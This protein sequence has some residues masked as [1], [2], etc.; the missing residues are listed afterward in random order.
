[1]IATR[2]I[3]NSVEKLKESV[4]RDRKMHEPQLVKMLDDGS[5]VKFNSRRNFN[6]I[7][8]HIHNNIE[9]IKDSKL[10]DNENH[11]KDNK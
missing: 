1:V 3:D 7:Y 8:N 4:E 11:G 2:D 5:D 9:D 6:A 10:R